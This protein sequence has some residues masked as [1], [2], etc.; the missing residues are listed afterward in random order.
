[1]EH[2]LP[3]RVPRVLAEAD[4]LRA[5][6]DAERVGDA[7]AR[8]G[9]GGELAWLDPPDVG[10]VTARDDENVSPDRGRLAQE[11]DDDLVGVDELLA[12]TPVDDL[13]RTLWKRRA[14]SPGLASLT[15]SGR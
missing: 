13:A 14:A 3:G 15:S 7:F 2:V 6:R 8:G 9:H 10:H 1:M 5:D 4:A 12:A 11:G